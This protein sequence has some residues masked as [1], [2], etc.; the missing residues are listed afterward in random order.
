MSLNVLWVEDE[1]DSLRAEVILARNHGWNITWADTVKQ[2]LDLLRDT[3]FDL[4]VVDLILP[5][6]DYEKKRGFVDVKAGI[7]LIGSIREPGRQGRTPPNV[8]LL[9]ITAVVTDELKAQ[10]VKE[11]ESDRYYLNKPLVEEVYIAVVNELTQRL[12]SCAQRSPEPGSS[13]SK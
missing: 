3:V 5:P 12:E 13:A 10:V 2:S 4:V 1:P 6:T 11:L 7:G 9:V 8:F